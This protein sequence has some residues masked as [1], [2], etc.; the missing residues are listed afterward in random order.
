MLSR[1]TTNS[2]SFL[3][4]RVTVTVM[5]DRCVNMPAH[6]QFA[7]IFAI[8]TIFAFL[9]AWNIGPYTSHYFS[10]QIHPWEEHSLTI[11]VPMMPPT[12]SRLLSPHAL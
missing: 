12:H 10:H 7:N 1:W 4:S 6:S 9:D 5:K 2:A 3:A 8:G 11:Q